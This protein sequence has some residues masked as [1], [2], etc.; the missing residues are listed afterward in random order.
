NV[1]V[2]TVGRLIDMRTAVINAGL[3][4]GSRVEAARGA[5]LGPHA[6][7]ARLVDRV[8]IV[9]T[10]GDDGRFDRRTRVVILVDRGVVESAVLFD[11]GVGCH[12]GRHPV[13]KR[14]SQG[15]CG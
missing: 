12:S 2:A 14:D 3:A 7:A 6:V 9:P 13:G 11:V 4:D 10:R 1:G 8:I 5:D 15:E